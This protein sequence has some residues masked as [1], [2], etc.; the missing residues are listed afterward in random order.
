LR[1]VFCSRFKPK[2]GIN[3]FSSQFIDGVPPEKAPP[4]PAR[5][6]LPPGHVASVDPLLESGIKILA[7]ETDMNRPRVPLRPPVRPTPVPTN[8]NFNPV[9]QADIDRAVNELH[10]QR[11][12]A[13]L[14]IGGSDG[15]GK[16]D[17]RSVAESD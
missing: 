8:P 6:Q 13:A 1:A 3:A 12:R 9:T 7:R 4:E 5:L 11:A 10:D 17:G 2:D 14:G 15:P 16:D